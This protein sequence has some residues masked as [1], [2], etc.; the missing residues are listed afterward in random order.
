MR[1]EYMIPDMEIVTLALQPL[2]AGSPDI[3]ITPDEDPVTPPEGS[4]APGLDVE[5][6]LGIGTGLPF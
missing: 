5:D 6:V 4:D 2:L 1:K 3:D